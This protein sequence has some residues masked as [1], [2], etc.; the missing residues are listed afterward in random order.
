M[1]ARGPIARREDKPVFL[2]IG[3]AACHWCHVMAHESF[4]NP[5]TAALMNQFFINIK[6]DREERPDL[7]SIYMDAVVA[8]TGQGGWPMSVFLTPEGVPFFGGTYFPPQR[9]YRM[10]G[11]TEVLA[12]V[13]RLWRE[14]R[15]QLTGSG[16]QILEHLQQGRSADL[17]PQAP[18]PAVLDQAAFRLVQAYDW[19]Y[20]GWGQAP[21]FPQPM[22]I[23]FLLRRAARGDDPLAL[24]AALHALQRMARGGMYDVVGGGFARYSTDDDWLVP[25]FEK[26]LYDNA[27]LARAY[28]FGYLAGGRP[29]FRRVCEAT[30]DFMLREL[31]DPMGGFYSS[32]DADSEGVEG[33]FYV[34]TADELEQVLRASQAAA[35]AALPVLDWLE[36]FSQAYDVSPG[37]NWEGR[38]VLQRRNSD[39]ELAEAFGLSD[40]Q[41]VELLERIHAAL[42]E[43]RSRRVRPATDD[44]VLTAWNGLA[45]LALAEAARY[46]DRPD[47]LRAARRCAAFLLAE[48]RPGEPLP[49]QAQ[50][51]GERR[52]LRSWRRG[53]A[54]HNAYLE[55]YAALALGLLALYQSDPDPAWFAAARALAEEMLAHYRDPRLGFFDTRDD[56]GELLLRP[57][58]LQDNA[59]PS[60]SALAAEVLVLLAAYT[61]QTG[62]RQIADDLFGALQQNFA[63][64]PTAFGKW[65]CAF[66]QADAGPNEL[67]ILAPDLDDPAARRLQAA[68]WSKL[69]PDLVAAAAVYPPAPGSPE[70][71]ADRPLLD[72]APTAYLCR[73]FACRRPTGDAEELLAQ[74]AGPAV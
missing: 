49:G 73:G 10:P 30:L 2:S 32:L 41:V 67:A 64:Y 7:D 68:L 35:P 40:S 27:Q 39:G 37:G 72:G 25:H 34:W 46:L 26:M 18:D 74:L 47:Y 22:A 16:Q 23:E 13:A 57:K 17:Q 14:D 9:R 50:A 38:I 3:Y 61:G 48:L 12:T 54:Q 28:L 58:D 53:R 45:L 6:V 36:F 15:A 19:Q 70:L 52:L 66:Y 65:L 43:A 71:L 8:M 1:S 59:T 51:A 33:K 62:W 55:D 11:F 29:D 56:Q 20:G 63:R 5:E 42:L 60:G 24:D 44:K 69:R 31:Q 4:E 21:R